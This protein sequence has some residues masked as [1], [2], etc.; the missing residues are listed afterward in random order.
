MKDLSKLTKRDV[1]LFTINK[2]VYEVRKKKE[3]RTHSNEALRLP[4]SFYK[5]NPK[6]SSPTCL[7]LQKKNKK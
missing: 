5:K 7:F 2:R 6:S 1:I 3:Q 4:A